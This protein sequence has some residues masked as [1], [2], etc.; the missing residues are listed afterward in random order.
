MNG[1]GN[2]QARANRR[3]VVVGSCNMDLVL[4]VARLPQ[5]GET[6]AGHDFQC[7][8][9]G[10]GANQAVAA[11]RLGAQVSLV[12]CVG[13]DSFGDTLASAFA[14]DGID[15]THLH[16]RG[17]AT[18]IAC[19]TVSDDG[20]NTI[21]LAAGANGALEVQDVECAE[22]LIAQ[23]SVLLCQLEVPLQVVVAAIEIAARH[24]TRV[25]LNPAPAVPLDPALLSRVD[26]LVPN[27]TEAGLLAGTSVS[28]LATAAAAAQAL[29]ARGP[30]QV[31]VT[32]GADGVWLA[33]AEGG[34]H[35]PA[36]RVEAVDSTAAGDTF[37]GGL[38]ACMAD[39]GDLQAAILF[40]QRAA[41]LSVTRLGA[42]TSIPS[43]Q[44]VDAFRW[45]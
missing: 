33:T 42:Q 32:L 36:P 21:V 12:G 34:R 2:M 18:G 11:A 45:V 27:E 29:L 37:I 3:V 7:V 9:G 20:L 14:A 13:T 16:R 44:E 23:A 31:L 10:K 15:I 40:G 17:A 6:L 25:V 28:D 35:L 26:Y 19:V 43:R 5:P 4:R 38:A 41:A 39:G 30:A 1:A 8:P 24:G 22:A